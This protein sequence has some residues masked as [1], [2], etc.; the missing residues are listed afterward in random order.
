MRSASDARCDE[1]HGL[2]DVAV[3]WAT[4]RPDVR[5][6]ALVGS[7]ASTSPVDPGSARVAADGLVALYDPDRLLGEL[8][9]A[10]A[11]R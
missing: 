6:V 4:G 10:A 11:D 2:V 8:V 3:R 1:V 7:W 5:A 9:D